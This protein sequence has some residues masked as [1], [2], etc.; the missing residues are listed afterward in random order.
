MYPRFANVKVVQR[1]R[2]LQEEIIFKKFVLHEFLVILY[3]NLTADTARAIEQKIH[4]FEN[5][6]SGTA[7]FRNFRENSHV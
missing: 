7:H 1:E 3:K 5:I 4:F 2:F 6:R